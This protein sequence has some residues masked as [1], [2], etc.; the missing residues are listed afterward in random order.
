MKITMEQVLENSK[1]RVPAGPD[2]GKTIL[3]RNIERM[4]AWKKSQA[5]ALFDE[6][7]QLSRSKETQDD[8]KT[9]SG[10]RRL[11]RESLK[12]IIKNAKMND[13]KLP[14][15]L[16]WQLAAMANELTSKEMILKKFKNAEVEY[17]IE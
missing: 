8:H 11:I 13:G 15:A 10:S 12:I 3:E 9:I 5:E 7:N 6:N 16:A 1:R 2:A 4:K 14:G 17:P